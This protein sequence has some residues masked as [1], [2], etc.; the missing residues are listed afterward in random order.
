M[1]F[2]DD[3][4]LMIHGNA[5]T[6]QPT[7]LGDTV[8]PSASYPS[9]AARSVSYL[10]DSLS[11]FKNP[12]TPSVVIQPAA[13]GIGQVGA[14]VQAVAESTKK[15]ATSAAG[16]V[17]LGLAAVVVIVALVLAAYVWRAFK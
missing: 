15:L 17:K 11:I 8:P 12:F 16:G 3:L 2:F 13:A 9:L 1:K 6:E 4:S 5:P 7:R 10:K 14:S